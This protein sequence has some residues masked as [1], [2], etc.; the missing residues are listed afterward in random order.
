MKVSEVAERWYATTV[1]LKPSTR[2][3]Y[4]TLLDTHVLPRWGNVELRRVTTSAVAAWTAEL[5]AQRS[6]STTRKALVVLGQILDLAAADRLIAVNPARARTIRRPAAAA[7]EMRALTVG[8]LDRLSTV[9]PKER[10]AVFVELLG[11]SGLRFGE[12]VAL[13]RSD[14]DVMRGRIRIARSA[15]EVHGTVIVGATKTHAAR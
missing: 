7:E 5:S 4:R 14:I 10:D 9:M 2:I 12:A 8:E 13:T 6:A 11:W 3:G 15:T 1:A